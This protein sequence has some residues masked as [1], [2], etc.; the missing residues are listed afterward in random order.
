MVR[1]AAIEA[2]ERML[3]PGGCRFRLARAAAFVVFFLLAVPFLVGSVSGMHP[4]GTLTLIVSTFLLQA[5][6]AVVGLSLGLH[7]AAVLIFL[8]SVAAAVMVAIL[9]LC[10]LFAEH[11]PRM[12]GF[13]AKINAETGRL[14][15]LRRYGVLMLIPVIW[16]PGV[17]LYG[18]PVVAWLFQYPRPTAL[19]CMIAGWA[20]AVAAVMAA[21]LGLVRLAF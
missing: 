3:S 14:H 7:P 12:Q 15:S 4:P 17:A 5:A 8:S 6:A 19:L 21:A 1:V 13:L 20:L 16:I 18:A 10:D 2:C 9:E 11:S